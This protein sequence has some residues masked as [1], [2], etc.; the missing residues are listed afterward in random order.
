MASSR[1]HERT[2]TIEVDVDRVRA[3]GL[4]KDEIGLDEPDEK[5]AFGSTLLR[6]AVTRLPSTTTVAGRDYAATEGRTRLRSLP[7]LVVQ[8]ADK[9]Q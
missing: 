2:R 8:V 4:I 1:P 9:A 7:V 5:G 6:E 3:S